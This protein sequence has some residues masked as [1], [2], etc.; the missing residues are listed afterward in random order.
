MKITIDIK[1]KMQ[2]RFQ[3]A[4]GKHAM[5]QVYGVSFFLAVKHQLFI[6]GKF[7]H[8]TRCIT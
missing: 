4:L 6:M 3:A 2:P 7:I 5:L 8:G 1:I